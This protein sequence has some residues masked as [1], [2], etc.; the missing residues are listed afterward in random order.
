MNSKDNRWSFCSE[1]PK[2]GIRVGTVLLVDKL[3]TV[4]TVSVHALRNFRSVCTYIGTRHV[5][6]KFYHPLIFL[7]IFLRIS[8]FSASR[9]VKVAS[10]LI[11]R[12]A[13]GAQRNQ[14]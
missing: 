13:T 6:V 8:L 14:L 11:R 10:I 1:R 7:L 12:M 3:S 9:S 4:E 5:S 2:T